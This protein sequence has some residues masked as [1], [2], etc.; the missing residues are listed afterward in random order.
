MITQTHNLT[1]AALGNQMQML[2]SP[3][4][5]PQVIEA[6]LPS[7]ALNSSRCHPFQSHA[8]PENLANG[9]GYQDSKVQGYLYQNNEDRSDENQDSLAPPIAPASLHWWN[10]P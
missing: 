7:L 5:M 1:A 3:F 8:L 2:W 10:C 6:L 9:L 4:A